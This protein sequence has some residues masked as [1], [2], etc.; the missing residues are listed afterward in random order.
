MASKSTHAEKTSADKKIVGFDFQYY[1][2]LYRVLQ[3]RVGQTVGFEVI[4]DVHC[5]LANDVQI[6]FQLKHT[7]QQ[8]ADGRP[9]KLTK[10]D[11]DLWK[12]LSNWSLVIRDEVA[13]RATEIEQREFLRKTE[14]ILA[15]NK[16]ELSDPTVRSLLDGNGSAT[17]TLTSLIE[18]TDSDDIKKYIR[19]VQGLRDLLPLFFEKVSLLLEI[20]QIIESCL[21][22]LLEKQIPQHR[23]ERLFS[24]LDSQIRKDNFLTIKAGQKIEISFES[25]SK[26]YRKYFDVARSTELE[27][28][29][30]YDPLPESLESQIFIRQLV[31]IDDFP[32]NDLDQMVEFTTTKRRS[33]KNFERW[34]LEG[35]WTAIQQE[36]FSEDARLY[37]FN[38]FRKMHRNQTEPEKHRARAIV[39]SLR[40]VKLCVEGQPLPLEFSNG[41]FYSLA[42]RPAIG[43]I[44]DWKTRY[45][46]ANS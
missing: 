9:E 26:T 1:F 5:T 4:D 44:K 6:L 15:S 27:V 29:R 12:T 40:E 8:Q 17:E 45:G 3:L 43:F 31:D 28:R 42:D 7:L 21:Q 11:A 23:V 36:Q 10:Y 25:F 35:D 2:F 30:D 14:F 38:S 34:S 24:D 37:W 16:S 39:D 41:H 46:G 32:P 22:L 33:E 19:D 13:G 20:D 18:G